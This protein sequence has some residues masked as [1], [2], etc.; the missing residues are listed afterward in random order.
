MVTLVTSKPTSPSKVL[1]GFAALYCLVL[2]ATS[3]TCGLVPV[4][5]VRLHCRAAAS[6]KGVLAGGVEVVLQQLKMLTP[7]VHAVDAGVK[8]DLSDR[9]Q[10]KQCDRHSIATLQFS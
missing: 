8:A 5:Q 4:H 1:H 9:Y 7:P 6:L 2:P 3:C 10:A